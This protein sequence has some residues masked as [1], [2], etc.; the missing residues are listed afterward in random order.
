MEYIVP[1]KVMEPSIWNP[2]VPY[3]KKFKF[4]LKKYFKIVC[5]DATCRRPRLGVSVAQKANKAYKT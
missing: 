1:F 4:E 2:V 3:T 5:T